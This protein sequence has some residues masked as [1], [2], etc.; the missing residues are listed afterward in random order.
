MGAKISVD[1][2]TMMNKGL[3]LIEAHHL[4]GL[5]EEQIEIVVHP[6]SV[7]PQPG[8]LRRRLGAGPARQPGHAHADR[9]RAGLAEAHRRRRGKRLDLAEIASLTFEAPDPV[10]FPALQLA[11]EALKAGGTAPTVLNAANEVAVQAFLDGPDRLPR[12]RRH[13]G[14]YARG[15][16]RRDAGLARSPARSRRGRP[17]ARATQSPPQLPRPHALETAGGKE[18]AAAWS[19]AALVCRRADQ[20]MLAARH[21]VSRGF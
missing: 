4:F 15:H 17:R 19:A 6:Q 5:P 8:R 20:S 12:H 11:R 16:A 2:A 10:R 21:S 9:L 1:S 7:D 14:A 3:E 13:R 18:R